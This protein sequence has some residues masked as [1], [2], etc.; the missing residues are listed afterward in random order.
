VRLGEGTTEAL[1]PDGRWVLSIG[2]NEKPAQIRMLPSGAGQPRKITSDGIEHRNARWFPDG[3]RILFLGNRGNEAPRL[4]VQSIDGGP[5]RPIAAEAAT[6]TLITPD[7]T[8]V[9]ARTKAR[10]WFFFPVDGDAAPQPVPLAPNDVPMRFASDGGLFVASFGK[11]PALL[12]R[13]DLA[14]GERTVTREVMPAQPA[15]LINVGPV[16]PT[17]DG[18][19]TVYS[20]TRLLSDLYLV[21]TAEAKRTSESGR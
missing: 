10:K 18:K 14:T 3:K 20:Y 13:V 16:W 15:G 11:I 6:G 12:T 17:P 4:W 1:S 8:R 21:E 2:R 7:G 19:T 5:P 9:L